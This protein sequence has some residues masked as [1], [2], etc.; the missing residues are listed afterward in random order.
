MTTDAVVDSPTP[1]AP[2]VVVC[3]HPQAMSAITNPNTKPLVHM[4]P[5]SEGSRNLRTK[6]QEK[7][8][9]EKWI[10][11]SLNTR[12]YSRSYTRQVF[13]GTGA[14][15]AAESMMAFGEMP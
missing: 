2:P 13:G 6:K 10:I 7:A 11:A 15:F 1:F 12:G 3:P 9:S 8:F 14:H 4:I 5:M